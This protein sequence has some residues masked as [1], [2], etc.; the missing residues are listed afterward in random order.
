ME[1]LIYAEGQSPPKTAIGDSLHKLTEICNI[2]QHP[3]PC[4]SSGSINVSLAQDST[5][6]SALTS[7]LFLEHKEKLIHRSNQ[8]MWNLLAQAHTHFM[9]K[10]KALPTLPSGPHLC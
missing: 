5:A 8:S 7:A 10:Y 9:K 4:H 3:L 6:G 1:D 2:V